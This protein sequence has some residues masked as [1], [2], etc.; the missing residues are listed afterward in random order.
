MYTSFNHRD[1]PTFEATVLNGARWQ[2]N[3][4][5]NY[6]KSIFNKKNLHTEIEDPLPLLFFW[7][8]TEN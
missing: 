7:R 2:D 8:I 6:D 3:G 1:S 5:E 4:T